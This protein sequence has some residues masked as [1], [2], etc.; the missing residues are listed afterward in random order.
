MI[1]RRDM[2]LVIPN[3]LAATLASPDFSLETSK[4][5]NK[6]VPMF[7]SDQGLLSDHLDY[8][9]F[10]LLAC[11]RAREFIVDHKIEFIEFALIV[12][13]ISIILAAGFVSTKGL[14]LYLVF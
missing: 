3:V 6:L 8:K 5:R 13:A 7:P 9:S 11:Q 12:L 10:F 2:L 1:T 4:M 14:V